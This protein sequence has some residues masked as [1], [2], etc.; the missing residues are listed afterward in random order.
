MW[1]GD[2]ASR[3]KLEPKGLV[4][5]LKL[6][7]KNSS[8]PDSYTIVVNELGNGVEWIMETI[9]LLHEAGGFEIVLPEVLIQKLR[10]N[11]MNQNQ[12]PLPTGP[13]SEQ[14]GNL[15][16]CWFPDDGGASCV[17]TCDTINALHIP[18]KCDLNVC[19][20]LRLTN[21]NTKF[22]CVETGETCPLS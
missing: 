3:D 19:S 10:T 22:V 21:F 1:G 7:P 15:P 8:S 18:V 11:T 13:W 12:C 5:Q 6:L 14:A 16:K 9:D 17:M 2:P 4:E 20:N